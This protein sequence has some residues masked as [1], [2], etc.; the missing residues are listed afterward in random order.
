MKYMAHHTSL[1]ARM[2]VLG[3]CLGL[4]VL[5]PAQA[6]TVTGPAD[7][8]R[9]KPETR[10]PKADRSRDSQVVVPKA[11]PSEQMPAG[12]QKVHLTLRKVTFEG[13]TVFT[14][15]E[16]ESTCA[17]YLNKDTTL[18]KLYE[19]A[20]RITQK[21]R[22][23]D[24]FLSLAYVPNQRIGK[25]GHMTIRVIEGHIAKVELPQEI[26]AQP[27][28]IAYAEALTAQR[29]ITSQAL[30]SFLLR[31]NDL[32]GFSYRAVLSP[33]GKEETGGVMLS[34]VAHRK[35]D[36]FSVTFDNNSSRYLGPNELLFS[37]AA[38]LLPMQHTT[39]SA[40]SSVP[41]DKLRYGMVN[42]SLTLAQDLLLELNGGITS[43][44]PG[45]TLKSSEIE[46]EA[47][48]LG[49][50]LTYQ[51]T[52]QRQENLSF[53]ATFDGRNVSSDILGTPLTRDRIRALRL[54]LNYDLA[55]QWAGYSAINL[56]VSQGIDLIGATEAGS[57]NQSRAGAKPDF[58]KIEFNLS[59][60]QNI[61][62][63][64]AVQTAT[65]GQYSSGPLYSS[66]EFGYGGQAFGRAYDSS[67]ITGNDGISGSLEL[68]YSGIDAVE[69]MVLQ[70]YAFYDIGKVWS[71][72]TGQP[73]EQ[74]GS[75]AG[76][77]LR[78]STPWH[79]SGN[80]GLAWP[81]TR[82]ISAPIY[83]GGTKGP[84][85]ILQLNQSF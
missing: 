53:K 77:G 58:S 46:S 8:G 27:I 44:N 19:I 43:A 82:D 59:R 79:Q 23:A 15:Q 3:V 62:D 31:M 26:S 22:D 49:V 67:D 54:G 56:V 63:N 75:S 48:S 68:R 57:L 61:S 12:A 2:L 47:I 85:I 78:F 50:S 74:S 34:L 37:Y 18:D 81:L 71:D 4:G 73:P 17:D 45:F 66:E 1:R 65:A 13:A 40:L 83:G 84:R 72:V 5:S 52:R 14:Q 21:Y 6:A 64:W 20:N 33:I 35:E 16:L 32:P 55:D 76:L 41:G 24:Y 69:S 42:H 60:L 9:I 29:P 70:P 28:A 10:M 25:D 11:A 7:I 36:H 38:D 30:E 39:I 80:L 51:Y